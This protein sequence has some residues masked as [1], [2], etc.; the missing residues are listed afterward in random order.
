MA[1]NNKDKNEGGIT[2]D[3]EELI[4]FLKENLK[5]DIWVEQCCDSPELHASISL[6]GEEISEST[7]FV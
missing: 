5:I 2:M 1:Y 3:K 6:C 7:A 4:Q